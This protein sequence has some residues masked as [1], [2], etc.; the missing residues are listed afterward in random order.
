MKKFFL[1]GLLV[2]ATS[3]SFAQALPETLALTMRGMSTGLKA[4]TAQA[5]NI[6]SNEA[7][8]AL[9]DQFVVLALH[10]KN[11]VPQVVASLPVEQQAAAIIQ[12]NALMDQTATLGQ[13]LAAAFRVNDNATAAAIL[14]QL[15][16]TKRDGHD[17]FK[18]D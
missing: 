2:L 9:A 6:Q 7:S 18:K 11:F 13:Q 5:A 14:K 17:Q 4:I 15:N 16:Q 3:V 12:Y 8:A 10:A 1:T